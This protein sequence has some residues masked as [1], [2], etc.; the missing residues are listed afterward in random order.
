MNSG[1]VRSGLIGRAEKTRSFGSSVLR[2]LRQY[3]WVEIGAS[4]SEVADELQ[5]EAGIEVLAL[6]GA[7]GTPM[8]VLTRE[9]LFTFLGKPFG[10]DLLG[11]SSVLELLE[12][13]RIIDANRD[14]FGVAA[15]LIGR[16]VEDGDLPEW[17][18][19]VDE[20]GRFRGSISRTDL[21]AFLSRMTQEDVELAGSLQERLVSG[22]DVFELA[23]YRGE[24]WSR[25]AKGVGGDLWFRKR[26][27]GDRSFVALCDV[28]GKGVAASLVVSM[29]WG[30]LRAFDLERGLGPLIAEINEAVL[31][32]FQ[33]E[34]Y[35]T[36]IF[37]ILEP[38]KGRIIWADMG[39]GH[40]ALRRAGRFRK[41]GTSHPNLPLG[42]ERGVAPG[43]FSIAMEPGDGILAFS[44]GIAEQEN[45][46]AEEFGERRLLEATAKALGAGNPL[47]E[48]LPALLDAHRGSR[49]QQDDMTLLWLEA[50]G[51]PRGQG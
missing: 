39:H 26:L 38:S 2:A 15:E 36:G 44:D 17:S 37:M 24:A 46:G 32:S 19:L 34:K 51:G 41:I 50:L 1:K 40:A 47:G 21:A 42:I 25:S 45:P 14:V 7:G 9:R 49:P 27:A 12:P 20:D 29:V 30:M 6:L 11:K 18:L 22:S 28:S 31:S 48:A 4:V 16:G 23:G 43:I 35:L 5:R 33:T 8:G 3:A 13:A 10:R